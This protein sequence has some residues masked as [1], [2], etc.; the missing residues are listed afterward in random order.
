MV[1]WVDEADQITL[2]CES[3]SADESLAAAITDSIRAICKVRGEVE[4]VTAG[5][6]PNDGKV[7][8]DIRKYD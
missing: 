4:I 8:D 2:R 1:D 5:S 3:D 6:L 7:I